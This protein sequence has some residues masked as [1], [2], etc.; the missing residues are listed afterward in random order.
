MFISR[1]IQIYRAETRHGI[2]TGAER[3]GKITSFIRAWT[4]SGRT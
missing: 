2:R 1:R 4:G 3:G